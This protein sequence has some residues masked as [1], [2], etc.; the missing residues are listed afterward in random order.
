MQTAGCLQAP[1]TI[2]GQSILGAGTLVVQGHAD[3]TNDGR[4]HPL[5]DY[6]L[7]DGESG[8]RKSVVDRCALW[9]HRHW[10]RSLHERCRGEALA[11]QNDGEAYRKARD[12]ALKQAKGREAK[13]VALDAFGPLPTPP[14]DAMLIVDEPTYE[15]LVKALRIGQPSMGLCADEEDG[16]L[17]SMG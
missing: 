5:S 2:C 3:V 12:E 8:E 9:P 6:L 7:T 10:E 1:D 11:Y 15:G 17:A 13:K 4:T 14:L 16:S